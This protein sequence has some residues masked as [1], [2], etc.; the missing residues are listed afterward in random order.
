MRGLKCKL[1]ALVS[2]LAALVFDASAFTASQRHICRSASS[3]KCCQDRPLLSHV[4]RP[5]N[6]RRQRLWMSMP[7]EEPPDPNRYT[8]ALRNTVVS[9]GAACLFGA[10][11]AS[12][13]GTDAGLEYFAGYLVEQSLSCDNLF[14]FLLLFEYFSVPIDYQGRVL[15]WGIIGAVLLRGIFVALGQ[16]ALESFQPVLL[17]FAGILLVSSYKLL[18]EGGQD[19]DEDQLHNNQIVKLSKRLLNATEE[20]DGNNFFTVVSSTVKACSSLRI[21]IVVL[22]ACLTLC[23][24]YIQAMAAVTNTL[25]LDTPMLLQSPS[26]ALH[27]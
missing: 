21:V 17:I 15:Q 27:S 10:G 19:E 3:Q 5:D 13:K 12:V 2:C 18:T 26:T 14:V 11:V 25:W 20:Y 4:S 23:M 6:R 8:I 1:V 22:L 16:A 9:V 24:V 7:R